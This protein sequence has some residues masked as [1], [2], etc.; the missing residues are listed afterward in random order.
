VNPKFQLFNTYKVCGVSGKPGP[1]R[2]EG[3]RQIPEGFYYINHFNPNSNYHL[4]LGINYPNISDKILSDALK[5]GGDIYI[6]GDCVSVGCF[7][8]TNEQIEDVYILSAVAKSSGQEYI[9]VHIF[10]GN[11]S[12]AKSRVKIQKLADEN[13]AYIPFIKSMQAV[14]YNFEKEKQI[15]P[16]MVN[17]KGQ[18]VIQEVEIP[19]EI[20]KSQDV[21]ALTKKINIRTHKER[22]YTSDEILNEVTSYP[23]FDGGNKA[24]LEFV[25]NLSEELVNYLDENQKKAYLY[26]SFIVNTDGTISN[27]E[28]KKGGTEFLNDKLITKLE[29][30]KNWTPASKDGK[31]VPYKMSQT[32]FIES[33]PSGPAGQ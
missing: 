30:T 1:K 23:V 11:F 2:K 4:S 6:H 21:V 13:A 17:S 14:F 9:P 32:F 24:Y 26:T 20:S 27:V 33:I 16:I 18:Y 3:D 28:V 29:N 31:S 7:A 5:P 15:P 19:V 22:T 10:P 8:I 12:N 25:K